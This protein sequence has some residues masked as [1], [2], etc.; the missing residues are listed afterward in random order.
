MLANN[1][2]SCYKDFDKNGLFLYYTNSCYGIARNAQLTSSV[3]VNN[4][5]DFFFDETSTIYNC[6]PI[7][8]LAAYAVIYAKIHW[9][10]SSHSQTAATHKMRIRFLLQR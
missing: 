1:L 5:I 8:M 3:A 6:I 2:L 7:V 10:S 9:S 4:L